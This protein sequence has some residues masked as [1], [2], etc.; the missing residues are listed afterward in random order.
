ML[1][2]T[3]RLS[4]NR[5]SWLL[6]KGFKFSNEWFSLKFHLNKEPHSR[7]SIV[8]SKKI[9]ALATDRNLIRRQVYEIIRKS[10]ATLPPTDYMIIIKPKFAEL[11]YAN[12]SIY[13]QETLQKISSK[14]K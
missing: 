1:N 8:V 12:K 3:Q 10:P 2:K 4:T 5:I 9:K 14:L 6:K 7:Y 11:S 13:L